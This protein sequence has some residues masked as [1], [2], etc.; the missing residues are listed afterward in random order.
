MEIKQTSLDAFKEINET[1]TAQ[2]QEDLVLEYIQEHKNGL[3]RQEISEKLEISINAVCGRVNK[4]LD[5]YKIFEEGT[6]LNQSTNKQ[7]A[8]LKVCR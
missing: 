2:T 8:I 4:L 3:T 6:R 7:N 1:G 5:K